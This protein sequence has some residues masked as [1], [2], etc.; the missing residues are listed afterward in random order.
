MNLYICQELKIYQNNI[1]DDSFFFLLHPFQFFFAYIYYLYL[2]PQTVKP[3]SLNL[4]GEK[5]DIFFSNFASVC[6][7]KK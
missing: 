2:L 6:C 7:A 4:C 5:L 1:N 3:K